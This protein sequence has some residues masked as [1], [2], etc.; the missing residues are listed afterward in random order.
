MEALYIE[1]GKCPRKVEIDGSLK[2]MQKLVGGFIECAY[3][4]PDV[5]LVC[6]GE[7]MIQGMP[8][9]RVIQKD[10]QALAAICGNFFLCEADGD[11][12]ISI[13][14]QNAEKYTKIFLHPEVLTKSGT[15]LYVM[16]LPVKGAPGQVLEI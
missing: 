4:F 15:N 9:N 16:K 10:G 3:Y 14:E 7:G 12:L 13:S 11:N 5:V 8:F 1:V 6:N 2:S